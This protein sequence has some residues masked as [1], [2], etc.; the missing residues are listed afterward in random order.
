MPASVP[1]ASPFPFDPTG[2]RLNA[3]KGLA[4]Q[5]YEAL[6]DRI[7]SGSIDPRVKLPTTREL[8]LALQISRT[9]VVR[10]YDQLYAEGYISARVGDGT[11]VSAP[12]SALTR[13]ANPASSAPQL[14]QLAQRLE[15]RRAPP[16][17]SGAP[18][19]FRLGLPPLDLFPSAIWSRLH[20]DFWRHTP[21]H[22]IGYS[23]PAGDLQL[24]SMLAGYLRHA[25]GLVCDPE[26]PSSLPPAPSK[27]I[28]TCAQ[29]CSIRANWRLLKI[30]AIN[31]P[32]RHWRWPGRA[33]AGSRS[34]PRGWSPSS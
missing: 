21:E 34:T 20:A 29:C 16:A 18:C 2:L 23:D 27:P 13:Q 3:G 28:F 26:Q 14:S 6:R 4:I 8:A 1:A 25:R 31:A 33:C 10:A 24:R 5:V 17:P 7:L 32:V 9:T 19:A 22:R 11:Y 30:P 15:Q 12:A